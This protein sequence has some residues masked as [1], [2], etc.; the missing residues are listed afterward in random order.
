MTLLTNNRFSDV[1][2]K[3]PLSVTFE[4]LEILKKLTFF[5]YMYILKMKI[6]ECCKPLRKP[7]QFFFMEKRLLV[8]S[9]HNGCSYR[10]FFISVLPSIFSK[11]NF[12]HNSPAKH[13]HLSQK[14]SFIPTP[15]S[16]F[17]KKSSF[18]PDSP[19]V[20]SK[21][22][23]FISASA[24]ILTWRSLFMAVLCVMFIVKGAF[25]YQPHVAF[26][27]ESFANPA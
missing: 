13:H 12:F 3:F 8:P 15:S 18:M 6:V 19:N 14:Y 11:N 5:I 24:G 26:S 27:T 17:S 21:R 20:L 16:I 23:L 25:L 22:N 7:F 2:K 10:S 9:Q 1:T 4:Y